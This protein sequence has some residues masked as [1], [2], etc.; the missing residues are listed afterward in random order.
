MRSA[1]KAY[2]Y[3]CPE[4]AQLAHE[5]TLSPLHQRLRQVMGIGRAIEFA[6]GGNQRVEPQ[7]KVYIEM[8]FS[9]P[10]GRYFVWLRGKS[11][12]NSDLTDSIWLQVDNQIGTWQGSVH[13]GNWNTF[14]PIGVY[15]WASDVHIPFAIELRH[16]GDHQIR[17]QPRQ[18][19]HRI[20][21][22]WLSRSQP[23]IPNTN[24]PIR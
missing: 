24:R 7:P 19:T 3:R 5:L 15:A 20:D 18:T 21:Q 22:I 2:R 4:L 6:S 14:H 11:D 23:R 12:I 1:P 10:A 8:R 9:A 13:L 16:S 17:I